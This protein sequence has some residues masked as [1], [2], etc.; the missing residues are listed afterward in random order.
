MVVCRLSLYGYLYRYLYGC[1]SRHPYTQSAYIVLQIVRH[2]KPIYVLKSYCSTPS[3]N[4]LT[5]MWLCHT[6]VSFKVNIFLL[7]VHILCV[8][9]TSLNVCI[10]SHLCY[11]L[12]TNITLFSLKTQKNN[13]KLEEIM[14]EFPL[15]FIRVYIQTFQRGIS[16]RVCSLH[17]PCVPK[18]NMCNFC[19]AYFSCLTTKLR[20]IIVIN[21]DML[22][23]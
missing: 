22:I 18:W 6:F 7:F 1:R 21:A 2:T 4:P 12:S 11:Y 15:I 16:V 3:R 13:E 9:S 19:T 5:L 20:K 17:S 8:P 23:K 10:P 14:G